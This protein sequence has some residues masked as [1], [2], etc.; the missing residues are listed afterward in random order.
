[1]SLSPESRAQQERI[2]NHCLEI[3]EHRTAVRGELWS[4]FDL[5]DALHNC[6]SK[7]ARA[8]AAA[9]ALAATAIEAPGRDLI[10]DEAL[11]S[12]LDL[13]NFAAFSIRHITGE[14]P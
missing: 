3:Y 10:I 13:I 12:L 7:L 6:K 8:N 5:F 11:D 9:N 2:F 1:M 14:K 4:E